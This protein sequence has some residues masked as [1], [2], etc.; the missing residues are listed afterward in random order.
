MKKIFKKLGMVVLVFMAIAIFAIYSHKGEMQSVLTSSS[1]VSNTK[2]GWGVK[3]AQ[4][5]ERPELR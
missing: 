4:N 3:R 2:I 1:T 5:H